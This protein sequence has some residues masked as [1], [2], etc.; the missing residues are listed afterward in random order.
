MKPVELIVT[1]TLYEA[2]DKMHQLPT[3]IRTPITDAL[4]S[5]DGA[6]HVAR[7]ILAEIAHNASVSVVFKAIAAVGGPTT[8][9]EIVQRITA[10]RDNQAAHAD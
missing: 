3:E 6:E 7:T 2:L 10:V 8:K 4:C 9:T 1:N 5:M